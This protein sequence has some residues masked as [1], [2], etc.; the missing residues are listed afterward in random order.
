LPQSVT[1]KDV[2]RTT[3]GDLVRV[4]LEFDGEVDYRQERIESPSRLYFDLK[5][6]HATPA[7]TDAV[8]T[9]TDTTVKNIRLGRPRQDTTRLVIDLDGVDSYSVFALYNPYRLTIDLR[10]S[11]APPVPTLAKNL[12]SKPESTLAGAPVAPKPVAPE[13][14][15]P[16]RPLPHPLASRTAPTVATRAVSEIV[17]APLPLI[18]S[19]PSL[20]PVSV[21]AIKGMAF[22]RVSSVLA[23]ESKRAETK[24]AD[25]R[26]AE[27]KAI[28]GKTTSGRQST[29]VA[30]VT[31]PPPAAVRQPVTPLRPTPPPP[32]LPSYAAAAP[33]APAPTAP[34]ANASGGFSIARQLGL[35]VSRIVIDPGHGGHDS[36]SLGAK[37]QE[38]E[39][40]L[41]VALRLEKLLQAE[42]GFDIVMTRRTDVFIP[43]EE[44]TALANR[45]QADLF[46][47]IHTNS[48]RNKQ[49]GGVE[50]YYL[51]FASNPEAE[52]VAARENAGAAQTMNHLPEIVKAIAL[53]NK[54]D[55][56]RD[57]AQMVQES[58]VGGLKT[59]DHQPPNRGVKQ[60]PFVVLIGAG[61]PSVLAEISFI[62]NANEGSLM[63]TGA[64]R[65]KVAESLFAAVKKYQRSLKN[66]GTVASQVTMDDANDR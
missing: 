33:D 11:P 6:T 54:L 9:Y 51:N 43:L 8:L 64:Y 46:L 49:A 25:I 62:T 17:D 65:Q 63:K 35:G 61:M 14:R 45:H 5:R 36:G 18:A 56:S 60:A 28:D 4:T 13:T 3:I 40:V 48:S 59:S 38:K 53:N 39:I 20:V 58:M 52:E 57:L 10:R 34:S 30:K 1:L 12:N 2:K 55:E 21:M 47:S 7:L 42:P 24:A 66:V 15:I 44:R 22:P 27:V 37:V 23:A 16:P 41:D 26:L 32:P 50:T 19:A 29:T 31:P